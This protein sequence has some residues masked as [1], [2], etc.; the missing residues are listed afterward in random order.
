MRRGNPGIAKIASVLR[1]AE[2]VNSLIRGSLA[3]FPEI[4]RLYRF[5]H[6]SRQRALRRRERAARM[7]WSA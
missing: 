5:A 1:L 3:G 6:E 7:D 2:T 4:A